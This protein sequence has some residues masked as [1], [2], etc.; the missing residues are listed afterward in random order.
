[1]SYKLTVSPE[2][3]AEVARI[4]TWWS[5]HRPKAPRLFQTELD[6][7]L[8]LIAEMP[9]IGTIARSSR[10]GNARCHRS[11]PQPLPPL[12]LRGVVTR[13][14]SCRSASSTETQPRLLQLP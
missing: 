7:A 14:P 1:M 3:L 4:A 8:A 5:Q 11:A 13:L 9:E 12:L 2:A 10:V 6:D